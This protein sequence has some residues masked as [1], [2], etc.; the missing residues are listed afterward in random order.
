MLGAGLGAGRL[1]YDGAE[2]SGPL[3]GSVSA[4]GTRCSGLGLR[5]FPGY[6]LIRAKLGALV[7]NWDNLVI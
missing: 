6:R 5:A 7:A 2:P 1:G 4:R 3:W